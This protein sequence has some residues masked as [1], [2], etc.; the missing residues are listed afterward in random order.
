[1]S[2][3]CCGCCGRCCICCVDKKTRDE[4]NDR[5]WVRAWKLLAFLA[6]ALAG[7]IYVA[8]VYGIMILNYT[9]FYVT[10]CMYIIVP[11]RAVMSY[12]PVRAVFGLMQLF[13]YAPYIQFFI[14][15]LVVSVTVTLKS[16]ERDENL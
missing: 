8:S 6:I 10:L 1:M 7:T 4:N 11:V 15:Y 3:G 16:P 14:Y 12:N 9:F 5:N 2:S 13:C